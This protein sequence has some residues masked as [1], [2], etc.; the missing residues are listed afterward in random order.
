MVRAI[1]LPGRMLGEIVCFYYSWKKSE[2]YDLWRAGRE[3]Q[4]DVKTT[5]LMGQMAESV[6]HGE[7]QPDG[8][9]AARKSGGEVNG[10]TTTT[11]RMAN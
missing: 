3:Q 5:D 11:T 7:K 1:Q 9:S 8:G 10:T 2:Q 6:L 4:P